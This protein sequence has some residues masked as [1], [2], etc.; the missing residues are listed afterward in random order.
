MNERVGTIVL[1]AFVAHTAWHWLERALGRAAC[2]Y[3][4][5]WPDFDTAFLAA[6]LRW[7][8]LAVLAGLAAWLLRPLAGGTTPTPGVP[9]ER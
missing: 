5:Q 4:P 2:A 8:M 3:Q 1:S 9:S 6:L 7:A